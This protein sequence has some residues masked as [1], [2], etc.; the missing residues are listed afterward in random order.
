MNL[1]KSEPSTM[2]DET[3]TMANNNTTNNKQNGELT[4][5]TTSANTALVAAMAAATTTSGASSRTKIND[6][7][8]GM[9]NIDKEK[10]NAIILKHSKSIQI[11]KLI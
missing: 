3:T 1:I 6:T 11:N 10:I 9:E 2:D 4:T 7:K 5:T 8:A